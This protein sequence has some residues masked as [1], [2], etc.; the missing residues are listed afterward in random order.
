MNF[1]DLAADL[2]SDVEL[3][4][5]LTKYIWHTLFEIF[6]FCPKIR[7]WFPEKIVNL[8][9]WKTRE[10]VVVLDFLAVDN[11]DFTRK[12]VKKFWVKNSWKIRFTLICSSYVFLQMIKILPVEHWQIWELNFLNSSKQFQ[13]SLESSL[14]P[15]LALFS[16]YT[17]PPVATDTTH[18]GKNSLS[19]NSTF[20]KKVIFVGQKHE[21]W[22]WKFRIFQVNQTLIGPRD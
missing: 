12:I 2:T 5:D 8:F 13:S 10:N 6:I 4:F 17:K 18:C 7:L 9:G 3:V 19:S 14:L 20:L 22:P 1:S 16:L 15:N 21:F 11:F